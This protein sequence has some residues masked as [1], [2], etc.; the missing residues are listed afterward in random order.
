MSLSHDFTHSLRKVFSGEIRTDLSTRL[1]YS[2]D[3]SIYQIEPLGVAF[4]RHREDLQAAMETC[5]RFK[6]PVLPRGAGSSLAGQA[7]GPALILDCSRHLNRLV[8]LDPESRTAVV[9]PGLVLASLNRLASRHGLQFG[10]DPASAERA[11]LGGCLA[12]NSTGAHSIVYGM[13]ADHVLSI[14]AIFSDGSQAAFGE[15]ALEAFSGQPSANTRM[16]AVRQAVGEIRRDYSG[17]I[18]E[19]WP[20]TWRRA[21]GYSLNYL[22]PWSPSQPPQWGREAGEYP[23]SRPGSLN[24]A[25]LL[26]G[27]EGTLAIISQARLR[28]V[29]VPR[30]AILCVL[31]Y[32]GIPHACDDTPELLLSQPSAIELIPGS[33]IRLARSLPAY[34][35]Q[36][37]FLSALKSS[38]GDPAGDP[39]ALLVVE[40][41]GEEQADLLTRARKVLAGREGFLAVSQAEQQKVWMVRKAGLGILMSMPG[42]L[43]PWSFIEDL[44]VPVD[45]LGRFVRELDKIL[46]AH[47]TTS[48]IYAH[49]SAGCL[50]IRPLLNLKTPAG[51]QMMHS[52]AAQ[53]V[54]LTLR[55]GGSVSGEHGDGAGRSKW[56]ERMY[57][58]RV[59]EAFRL[60]KRAADPH[61]LL[62]PGK[63]VSLDPDKPL[64]A[65]QATLRYD[66]GYVAR[67]WAPSLDFTRQEGL[68]AAIE[69]CNGA[70]V[71]RK[72]DGVMCPSFQV[73]RDEM[74]S[75]RGRANLLRSLITGKF[76]AERV[77]E[78]AVF[79]ALDL[80]LAC[81]GCKAECP[82]AVD[83][84]KLK[85]EFISHYYSQGGFSRRRPWR[86]YLFG[87]IGELSAA[88][89]P[90]SAV[91][92]SLVS[93]KLTGGF[94]NRIAG[95][96]PRRRLPLLAR[97]PLNGLLDEDFAGAEDASQPVLLLLDV[98]TENFFP[99]IGLAALKV[100]RMTGC[101][102]KTL[103]V[104]G[105]GRTFLSKG[106][107]KQARAQAARVVESIHLLDP[108]GKIPVVGLEPSEIYTL[109]DEYQDLLPDNGL[110]KALKDRVFTIEE[111]MIRPRAE[112]SQA[113]LMR[114]DIE[115]KNLRVLLH[116]HC[117]QKAQPPSA[118]GYPN[119]VGATVEFLK[120]SGCQVEV[121]ETGCCGMA[122]AFGY[123]KEHFD[124]SMQVG[125][126]VL[127]PALR[128]TNPDTLVIAPG[129]S[130]RSQIKDG[131]GRQALH[132]VVL[133]ASL[134]E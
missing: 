23:P 87:Y 120:L 15:T 118:D 41:S 21:S 122:G 35:S 125:E 74:H 39:A 1:L 134:L 94:F 12:N 59:I 66:Q 124:L 64:S 63:I 30:H 112:E 73:T 103:T 54:E 117:Y 78:Q 121:L 58:E 132:P 48:E 76:P 65:M 70:G 52:I 130:C 14:D 43:K 123:E 13:T 133:L 80:C 24:L 100:L 71:C 119:G 126:Q 8:E 61:G 27:S 79:Q 37:G 93:S 19:A 50:H 49:A 33:M 131:T 32:P 116:G 95:I 25:P 17:A 36:L 56:L 88:A 104:R 5:A 129:L 34:A 31:S 82:S 38:G 46:A 128:Q 44:A 115:P 99:E 89:R 101:Q 108:D 98:F 29:P 16:E 72:E 40:F 127:F 26:A 45:T 51:V 20:R 2:T 84:A 62:N 4:P 107:V 106:L 85:Y 91:V 97:K 68:A 11:T 53:A 86:D 109:G 28:L 22:L 3:A 42:D 83:M 75:T 7:I 9:E 47:Q 67:A 92:N 18:Q 102:V 57:G 105:S 110:V 114:I 69:Q 113:R 77:G 96:H 6:V 90:F 111:F 81:K 60:L 55:L 10:P